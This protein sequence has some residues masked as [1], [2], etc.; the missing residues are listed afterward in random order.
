MPIA[1]GL[2]QAAAAFN[3]GYGD[4]VFD[5]AAAINDLSQLAIA[6]AQGV[7]FEHPACG[8]THGPGKQEIDVWHLAL[9][10]GEYT[11]GLLAQKSA[12]GQCPTPEHRPC[13]QMAQAHL[14]MLIAF[15]KALEALVAE[16]AELERQVRAKTEDLSKPR[17]T[18][19]RE[20]A[21][22]DG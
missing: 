4:G 1:E 10:L 9:L 17:L 7:V 3:K 22:R 5:W 16:M 11:A 2:K 14:D 19:T 18:V 15:R 8:S 20:L 13:P 12:E 6:R 21:L